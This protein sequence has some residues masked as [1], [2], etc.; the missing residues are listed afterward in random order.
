[1][2]KFDAT[3]AKKLVLTGAY[4]DLDIHE[5]AGMLYKA[6]TA[7]TSAEAKDN[8]SLGTL[9][10]WKERGDKLAADL[11]QKGHGPWAAH[12][13]PDDGCG[14]CEAIAEYRGDK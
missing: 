3:A 14:I 2:S 6:A 5:L 7:I 9:R 4:K 10:Q 11:Q 8:V 13:G 12:D 1:M